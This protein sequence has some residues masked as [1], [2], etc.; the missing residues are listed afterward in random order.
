MTATHEKLSELQLYVD[1]EEQLLICFRTECGY[2]LSVE[3]SQVTSHLRDKHNVAA[4]LRRGIT[5]ILKHEYAGFF[6]NP[7]EVAERADGALIHAKLHLYEGFACRECDY[8]T[9]NYPELSRHISKEHL[10]GRQ[11]SRS[12]LDDHYDDVYLQSWTHGG[13]RKYWI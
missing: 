5:H 13:S 8:R 2:A 9:I 1:R 10:N 11:A 6:R 3:R 7:A 12:R 4:D